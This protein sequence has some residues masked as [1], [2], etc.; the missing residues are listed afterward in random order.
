M[1]RHGYTAHWFHTTKHCPNFI[2][3]DIDYTMLESL[4]HEDDNI[5]PP[6]L[7]DADYVNDDD[8]QANFTNSTRI[9]PVSVEYNSLTTHHASLA[10]MWNDWYGE[11]AQADFPRIFV[12][13]ED[14]VF[15]TSNVTEQICQ[16]AGGRLSTKRKFQ[17][18]R[19]SAK[20]DEL[21]E[22]Q[23]ETTMLDAMI[24]YG[25]A[26]NQDR[27]KGMTQEDAAYAQS[28]L[29]PDLM[30][31]FGYSYPNEKQE[32]EVPSTWSWRWWR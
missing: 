17:Y 19:N 16:C 23:Y 28:V 8:P 6:Q 30:D 1:C 7:D 9:I 25:S 10:E 32:E 26:T 15:H 24:R 12:R 18:V 21:H 5:T 2:P 14:L 31:M 4:Q 27:L 22:F 3:S 29:R 20:E 13:M 11:Y